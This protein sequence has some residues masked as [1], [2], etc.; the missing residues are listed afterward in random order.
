MFPAQPSHSIQLIAESV[1]Q[2]SDFYIKNPDAETPWNQG[3]CQIAYRNYFLPLNQLRCAKVIER[4]QNVNFF[5]DLTH[6]VDWGSGPGTASF[7]LS[8]NPH[9]RSQIK[10]QF[11]IDIS[12]GPHKHFSDLHKDLISPAFSTTLDFKP[13]LDQ[14][15]RTC[16]VFSYSMTEIDRLPNGWDQFEAIMILEPATSQDGRKLLELRQDLISKG[17][18]MWAPCLHQLQCPLLKNSKTDWCHDR[19]HVDA[20]EWFW[21]VDHLLPMKNKTVT[22]SYLLARKKPAP[23]YPT[24]YGRLTGDSREEKGKTRQLICRNEEREFLTWMHK[25]IQPQTFPRGEIAEIPETFE[26]KSNELRVKTNCQ[27]K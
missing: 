18:Y 26:F 1:L 19:F 9:L 23:T 27:L 8:Q 24:N 17:Y 7:A 15:N 25:E 2:L 16:A 3:F 5:Q 21:K 20:P 4:G 13:Y 12:S 22:T 14:K 10:K 11:L 6:F